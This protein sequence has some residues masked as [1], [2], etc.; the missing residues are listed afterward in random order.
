M[1]RVF[2]AI[3][4]PD[5]L[6]QQ[7][8]MAQ[9]LL[10]LPRRVDPTLFHLTLVFLGDTGDDVLETLDAALQKQTSPAVP[11]ALSGF[12]CFGGPK[13]RSAHALVRP[14][15]S[16]IRLQSRL[17]ATCRHAGARVEHRRFIPHITLGRFAPP[18]LPEAMRLERALVS[19]PVPEQAFLANDVTLYQSHL[20]AK[21]PWYEPLARYPLIA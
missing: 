21:A 2:L 12:D 19:A 5:A 15:P 13:P 4:L 18:P 11:I 6:R 16:L 9:F 20:A 8:V 17:E 10:P 7:L 14:D 3:D 1:R